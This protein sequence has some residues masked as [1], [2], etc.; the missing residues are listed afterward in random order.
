MAKMEEVYG[1][2]IDPADL[3][4]RYTDVTV[5]HL[6]GT[7]W[8][9]DT[10]ELRDRR[11][12]TIGVLAAQDKPELLELQFENALRRRQWS[13]GDR[14]PA[15]C[16][17][18]RRRRGLNDAVPYSRIEIEEAAPGVRVVAF[19]RPEVRN[20]FDTAM[21]QEVTAALRAADSD[22]AVGAVVLTG[23]GT[24]FTSGQDP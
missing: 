24:A 10:I 3:P 13:G 16:R 7:I 18:G 23:R 9:D 8:T 14:H 17:H 6:F 4:G 12:L 1:F 15:P 19:N 20:A 2:T 22:E 11:I 21:Y 5:D